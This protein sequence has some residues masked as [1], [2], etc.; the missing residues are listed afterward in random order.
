MKISSLSILLFVFALVSSTAAQKLTAEEIVTKH[1]DAVGSTKNRAALKNQ[2]AIGKAKFNVLRAKGSGTEGQVVFASEGKKMIVGMKFPD[3]NYPQDRFGFDGSS[4]KV[5][6]MIPG[7]R[8]LVGGFLYRHENILEQGLLGGVLSSAWSLYDLP[9][10][11]AKIEMDGT[12]KINGREA[13]VIDYQP[14]GGT[15]TSIKLFFDTENYQH[16]RSEYIFVV[17]ATQGASVDSSASRR[18]TRETMV[19]E[20]SNFKKEMGLNL[21]HSYRMYLAF[22]RGSGTTEYEWNMEFSDFYFN[23]SLEANSFDINAN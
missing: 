23:Q 1:L 9:A 13:Y 4:A 19:E 12:R 20:F 8:S 17:P 11:K 10:R 15:D 22:D 6:F 18:G 16:V 2:V 14:K 7:A 3:P 5:A 21:P